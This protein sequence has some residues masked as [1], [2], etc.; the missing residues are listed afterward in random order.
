M[1]YH[2]IDGNQKRYSSFADVDC[3]IDHIEYI[4]IK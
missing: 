1:N 2:T 3:F 4:E